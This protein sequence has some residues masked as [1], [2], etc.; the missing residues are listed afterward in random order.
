LGDKGYPLI[1]WIMMP[2][3]EE[4]QH[5][6]LKLLYHRKHKRGKSIVE[7]VFGIL[8]KTFRKVQKSK[9]HVAFLPDV[10]TCC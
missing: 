2:F 6:I 10:F 8:K 9:L 7:N 4:M 5:S 1:S 3:K